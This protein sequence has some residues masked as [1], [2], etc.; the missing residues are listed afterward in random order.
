[1]SLTPFVTAPLVG[2]S[3]A[4]ALLLSLPAVWRWGRSGERECAL[5]LV[6]AVA[7]DLAIQLLVPDAPISL[8]HTIGTLLA[9]LLVSRNALSSA[10]FYPLAMAAALLIAAITHGLFWSGLINS[11]LSY[12][13]IVTTMDAATIAALWIGCMQNRSGLNHAD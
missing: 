12:P 11:K 3:L 4:A 5:A 13:I 6:F 7:L 8:A 1:M 9:L 2:W 10:R